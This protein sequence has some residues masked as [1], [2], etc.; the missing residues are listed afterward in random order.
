[1]S[2]V[3]LIVFDFD[4]RGPLK[5]LIL[6]TSNSKVV[7]SSHQASKVVGALGEGVKK[8]KTI[9]FDFFLVWL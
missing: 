4:K 6:N 2:V 5:W 8:K 7:G 1:M 3:I 9:V